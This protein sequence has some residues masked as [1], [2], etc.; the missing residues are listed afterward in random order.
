MNHL[1]GQRG[2]VQVEYE[3]VTSVLRTTV[4]QQGPEHGSAGMSEF[5]TFGAVSGRR[6][7]GG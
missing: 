4:L 5:P 1:Y 6:D 2:N 7:A 3:E